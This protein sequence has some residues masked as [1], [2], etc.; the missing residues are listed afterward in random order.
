MSLKKENK[1]F[2]PK[3]RSS[4]FTFSVCVSVC[5][6][7]CLSVCLSVCLFAACRSQFLALDADFWHEGSLG[8][9]FEM[10]FLFFEIFRFDLL[11]AIFSFFE[12]FLLYILCKFQMVCRSNQG[13]RD[14]NFCIWDLCM[15][16]IKAC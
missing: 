16:I 1:K 7:L 15:I 2:F 6:S 5:L 14:L 9:P 13:H 11:M 10:H 8:E 3:K 12:F 4:V